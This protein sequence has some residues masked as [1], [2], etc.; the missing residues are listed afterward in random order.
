MEITNLGIGIMVVILGCMLVIGGIALSIILMKE[1]RRWKN[2]MTVPLG[3]DLPDFGQGLLVPMLKQT[4]LELL[5]WT[6]VYVRIG[7][8]IGGA[9]VSLV[10]LV[11]IVIGIYI[12]S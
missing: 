10:G 2:L 3:M 8:L 11:L 6:F 4:V 1:G 7:A 5:E 9:G 12:W